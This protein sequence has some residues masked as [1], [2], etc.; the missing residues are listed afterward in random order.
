V[1]GDD[2]LGAVHELG[3]VGRLHHG[4]AFTPSVA[5][6]GR[7]VEE[8]D[9]AMLLD[10]EAGAERGDEIQGDPAEF[11]GL[12]THGRFLRGVG[13]GQSDGRCGVDVCTT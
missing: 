1:L 13:L 11:E 2:E 7:H 6:V 9:V 12:K 8:Q 10:T 3:G 4:D 5:D